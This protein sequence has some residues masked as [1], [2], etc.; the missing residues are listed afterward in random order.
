MLQKSNY[1]INVLLTD[2]LIKF[3]LKLYSM[4]YLIITT[5]ELATP[6]EN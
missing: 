1:I 3:D 2:S 6:T 4:Q 5:H